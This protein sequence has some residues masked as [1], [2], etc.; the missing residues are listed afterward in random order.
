MNKNDIWDQIRVDKTKFEPI[1]T[2][3]IF[4]FGQLSCELG[5]IVTRYDFLWARRMILSNVLVWLQLDP[6]S[7]LVN[8]S[9]EL[10]QIMTRYNFFGLDEWFWTMFD[11]VWAMFEPTPTWSNFYFGQLF[12]WMR[13][14]MTRYD[15]INYGL[16]EWFWAMF[17]LTST[18]SNFSFGQHFMWIGANNDQI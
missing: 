4:T 15:L 3:P 2:L 10:G 17:E 5:Q 12:M 6:I 14:L 1:I 7:L 11:W 16:D 9:C 18:W 13:Q 8:F